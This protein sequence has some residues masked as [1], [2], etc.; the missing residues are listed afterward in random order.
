MI[1]KISKPVN[2]VLQ[3]VDPVC[4][5]PLTNKNMSTLA[6]QAMGGKDWVT[7]IWIIEIFYIDF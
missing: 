5:K 1:I 4:Y 7:S 2:W 6:Y 3:S